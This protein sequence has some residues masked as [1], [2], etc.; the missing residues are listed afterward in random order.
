[1]LLLIPSVPAEVFVSNEDTAEPTSGYYWPTAGWRNC[2]PEEQGMNSTILQ[3][4]IDHIIDAKLDVHS[5]IV[6][7][8]A[9]VVLEE[10]PNPYQGQSRTMSFQGTH[11]LYSVTKSFSSCLIGMAIYQELIDNVSQTVLS[12]FPNMTFS[13]V[14]ERKERMTLWDLLTMRSGL[15]WDE[16]TYPF[17]DA[18][19]DVYQVN[20]NSSGGVQYELDRPM[21]YDPGTGFLYN[22]G[23]SHILSGIVQETTGMTT[24]E[25]ATEYLFNPLNISPVFWP[26]DMKGVNFGGFDLQLRPLDMAKFGYL[27]LNRGVWDRERILP[28]GWVQNTTTTVTT[29]SPTHGYAAQ[30]HTMPDMDVYYAAGLYGQYI[31]VSP[32]YNIVAV[33]T[34]G[35]GMNDYDENP[36]MFRDY[37]LA[38]AGEV[39]PPESDL[40]HVWIVLAISVPLVAVVIVYYRK[41][42]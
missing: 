22:T 38:A 30:W 25:F 2:T 4:M 16:T 40:L 21:E 1:M 31:F 42:H 14:D 7:R 19:N 8:N 12:F 5:V 23:A 41:T 28:G 37:I 27:Y 3:E 33:F 6:T 29:L 35:Y 34:S 10:Y 39:P 11:Y 36:R 26:S 13:N 32:E 18:R 17:N 9:Y 20:F 24:L 15:P